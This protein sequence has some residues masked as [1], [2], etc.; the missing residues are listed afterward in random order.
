[1]LKYNSD[2]VMAYFMIS[3]FQNG[4]PS[5]PHPLSSTHQFHTKG[6]LLFSPEIPQ[7]HTKKP[8]GSTPKT[9]QFHPPSQFHTP[10]SSTHQFHTKGPLLFSPKNSSVPHQKPRSSTPKT[11]RFNTKNPSVPHTPVWN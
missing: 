11:P 5:V 8:L 4:S 3:E 7:F 10:L 6:P 1:M 9:P 2:C